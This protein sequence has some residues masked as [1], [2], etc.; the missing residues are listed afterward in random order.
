MDRI[1]T[2]SATELLKRGDT[3]ILRDLLLDINKEYTT[4]YDEVAIPNYIRA[5]ILIELHSS[6]Y[7]SVQIYADSLTP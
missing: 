2:T 6:F 5:Q 3:E 1:Q 7:K 4:P